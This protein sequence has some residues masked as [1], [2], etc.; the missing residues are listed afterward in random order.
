MKQSFK[1]LKKIMNRKNMIGINFLIICIICSG[2]I[3]PVIIW[4]YKLIIDYAGHIMG[5]SLFSIFLLLFFYEIFQVILHITTV[6]KEHF[7]L[8]VNYSFD[9]RILAAIHEKIKKIEIE[10]LDNSETYDLIDRIGSL[11]DEF[12]ELLTDLVQIVTLLFSFLI[13]FKDDLIKVL[14]LNAAIPQILAGIETR[15]SGSILSIISVIFS[16]DTA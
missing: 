13:Y 4:G 9:K 7:Q 15:H 1:L 5:K 16:L 14:S 6:I 8:R 12:L 11:S 2:I 3:E 10:E